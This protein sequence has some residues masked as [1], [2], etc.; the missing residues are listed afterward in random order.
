MDIA[1]TGGLGAITIAGWRLY[2]GDGS[3]VD[4]RTTEWA[5][6][7]ADDVQALIVFYNETY[8]IHEADGLK[9]YSYR[10][11]YCQ[12]DYYWEDGAGTAEE[13]LGHADVKRGKLLPDNQW[14]ALYEH[15]HADMEL[16]ENI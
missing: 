4:S 16:Q 9:T 12:Q 14:W 2:Y 10:K 8:L 5:D 1:K 7:P 6:A 3:I 11:V 13:A 15:I